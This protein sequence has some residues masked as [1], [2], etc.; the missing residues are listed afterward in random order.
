[1]NYTFNKFMV[2]NIIKTLP[3]SQNSSVYQIAKFKLKT[4]LRS[5]AQSS[6]PQL[7]KM[8]KNVP[9]MKAKLMGRNR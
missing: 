1:M 5:R 6:I 2:V 8:V 7:I 3:S 9:H 4:K